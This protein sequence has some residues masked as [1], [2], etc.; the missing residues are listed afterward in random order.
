L[1]IAKCVYCS[2]IKTNIS[3]E[4]SYQLNFNV[5]Y[6]T[7]RSDILIHLAQWQ[8]WW[9]FWFALVWSFY[10]LFMIKVIRFRVLKMRPKI[11]TSFR[12]HGKW[13]DFL[14]CIIPMIWCLNILANSNFILR[15]IEWQ[16]ES[17]LFTVRVRARQWYWIYKFELK[18][19]TD[20]MSAPKNIGFNKWTINTFSDLQTSDDYLHIIQ[21]RSQNKWI[22]KYW[23]DSLKKTIKEKKK[24]HSYNSRTK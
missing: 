13:G 7:T 4:A 23:S 11:S 6:S 24:S 3:T 10:Y 18:S 1:Q 20:I 5:G 14:A 21:L 9:W 16:S 17:S 22:K 19:F 2:L 12:P 8:Y 15:L